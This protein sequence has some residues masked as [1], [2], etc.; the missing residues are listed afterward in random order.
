C[1]R[2]IDTP[3]VLH[4]FRRV[5][6]PDGSLALVTAL[7]EGHRLEDVP[8]APGEQRWFAYRRADRLGRQLR[9]AGFRLLIDD[10]VTTNR[11]WLTVLAEAV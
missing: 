3:R 10:V 11:E 9:E 1:S 6:K 4:G 5:L 2:F 8:Y 7:G